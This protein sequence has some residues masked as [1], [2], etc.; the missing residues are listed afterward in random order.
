M[1][2]YSYWIIRRMPKNLRKIKILNNK[3]N[4]I[5]FVCFFAALSIVIASC[6]DNNKLERRSLSGFSI[7]Y[8]HS[9]ILDTTGAKSIDTDIGRIITHD[10]DTVIYEYGK[11]IYGITE[12]PKTIVPIDQKHYWDSV[13]M[14]S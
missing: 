2:I 10:N 12:F 8:P 1:A 5:F 14:A 11:G 3:I 9:W 4:I 13:G 6:S 7:E